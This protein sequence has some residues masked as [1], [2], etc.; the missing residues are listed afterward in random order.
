MDQHQDFNSSLDGH[1]AVQFNSGETTASAALANM[2]L[3]EPQDQQEV[4]KPNGMPDAHMGPGVTE[5]T[6]GMTATGQEELTASLSPTPG[7]VSPATES[8]RSSRSGFADGGSEDGERAGSVSPR[9]SPSAPEAPIERDTPRL[10]SPDSLGSEV[11]RSS[12]DKVSDV[13]VGHSLSG[14]GSEDEDEKDVCE[15]KESPTSAYEDRISPGKPQSPLFMEKEG[16]K[17]QV[18]EEK[19]EDS[20]EEEEER[21]EVSTI[22]RRPRREI[23]SEEEEQQKDEGRAPV[24]PVAMTPEEAKQRVLSF[25]YT[26]PEGHHPGQ[27]IPAGWQNGTDKTPPESKSPDSNRADPGSPFSPSTAA[28]RTQDQSPLIEHQPDARDAV[29]QETEEVVQEEEEVQEKVASPLPMIAVPQMEVEPVQKDDEPAKTSNDTQGQY[30][31]SADEDVIAAVTAAQSVTKAKP[32]EAKP[33]ETKPK[34]GKPASGLKGDAKGGAPTAAKGPV[35]K[36]KKVTATAVAPP[37]KATAAKTQKAPPKDAAPPGGKANAPGAQLKAKAGAGAGKE[38]AEKKTPNA[39]TPVKASTPKR[40]SSVQTTPN[41][42][43]WSS[44]SAPA[45]NTSRPSSI[46]KPSPGSARAREPRPRTG[47]GKTASTRTPGAKL[48]GAGTRMQTKTTAGVDSPKTPQDRSG[49]SSPSTPKSPASREVK[50]VAVVR[51]PPKSPGSMRGRSPVPLAAPMPDLKNVRSKIGSTENIKHSP[52]G[53]RV[54]IVEKKMDLS[55]VQSKCGSKANLKYTP[56]GGNVQ[57]T[58]KKIDLSNVQSKCGSKANIHHKPGGGNVEIKSEKMD[59]KVQSKIGSMDNVGHVAGG[60]GRKIESHK[61]SFRET[62]K[63][64]TDHGAEIVPVEIIAGGSPARLL[65]NVSSPG[66]QNMTET[67]PLSMLADQVSASLAKQGL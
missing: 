57:I 32:A 11:K 10:F 17:E 31:E 45:C 43:P 34:A 28:D 7:G 22:R 51:T 2:T 30:L 3:K 13:S 67:P 29:E 60:G 53:G 8:G 39:T 12:S 44:S 24:I 36:D 48:Q 42:K 64:R 38:A 50:K 37:P 35:R 52:G 1:A 23:S 27:G 54:Q 21:T 25:D 9:A 62:A 46:F 15:S 56:G 66:S 47:D 41:K 58:H 59:F 26:E 6:G 33:S 49:Y 18:D 20:D 63:A 61:L 40:P 55:N 5:A 65:S 4:K 14:S 16:M 19:E